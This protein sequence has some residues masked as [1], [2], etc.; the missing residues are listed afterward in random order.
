MGL[1]TIQ[2]KPR[3]ARSARG[4]SVPSVTSVSVVK[5]KVIM[6]ES[7]KLFKALRLIPSS[8][9]NGGRT[10]D[11]GV[12]MGTQWRYYVTDE[13]YWRVWAELNSN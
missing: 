2:S 12:L 5:R 11:S 8:R 10:A 4:L 3:P 6:S 13:L 7:D 9:F 1:S